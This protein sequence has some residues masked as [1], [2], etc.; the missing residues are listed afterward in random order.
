MLL[1]YRGGFIPKCNKHIVYFMIYRA[2]LQ[3]EL[4]RRVTLDIILS[5]QSFKFDT[6]SRVIDLGGNYSQFDKNQIEHLW[7]LVHC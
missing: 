5:P 7:L 1:T 2:T 6:V 3:S 4:P